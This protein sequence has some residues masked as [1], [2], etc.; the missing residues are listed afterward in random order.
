MILVLVWIKK[1]KQTAGSVVEETLLQEREEVREDI[2]QGGTKL[3]LLQKVWLISTS[4][5]ENIYH[6]HTTFFRW[7]LA[8][9]FESKHKS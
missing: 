6:V 4:V 2:A 9:F 1:K 5:S 8:L 7:V 3:K